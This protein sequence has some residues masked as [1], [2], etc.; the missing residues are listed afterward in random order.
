MS[1]TL[2]SDMLQLVVISRHTQPTKKCV[3][4][5]SD[6]LQLVVDLHNTQAYRNISRL[7]CAVRKGGKR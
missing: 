4:Q 1:D 6:K 2:M 7:V 5:M 3:N